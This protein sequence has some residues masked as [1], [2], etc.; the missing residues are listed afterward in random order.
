M[1]KDTNK[2]IIGA[3]QN[4]GKELLLSFYEVK[5]RDESIKIYEVTKKHYVHL[6]IFLDN[7][8]IGQIEKSLIRQNNL[9][10]YTLFLLDKYSRFKDILILFVGYFDNWN[11]SGTGEFVMKKKEIVWEWTYS[12]AN[13]KYNKKWL[14][15]NFDISEEHKLA[16]ENEEMGLIVKILFVILGLAGLSVLVFAIVVRFN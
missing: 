3:M 5:F 10:Q 14:Q 13:E 8:Q 7:R 1:V 4:I 9:D 16:I 6:L 11:Y 12:K 2:N 15:E